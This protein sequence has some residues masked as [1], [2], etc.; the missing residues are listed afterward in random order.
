MF[1]LWLPAP[2]PGRRGYALNRS[3][4]FDTVRQV[5]E[6]LCYVALDFQKEVKVGWVV[7]VGGDL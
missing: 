1:L 6:V 5:K 2:L 4:D 3:A 7:W